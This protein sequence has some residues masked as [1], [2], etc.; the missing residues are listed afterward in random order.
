MIGHLVFWIGT[1]R[2]TAG[3]DETLAWSCDDPGVADE[4]NQ[5]FPGEPAQGTPNIVVGRHLLYQTAERVGGRVEV[6]TRR[7]SQAELV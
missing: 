6:P 4:L 7:V 3:L 5:T 1:K 2:H